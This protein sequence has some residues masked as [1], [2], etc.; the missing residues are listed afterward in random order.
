MKTFLLWSI[1]IASVI[2]AG[3]VYLLF[4]TTPEKEAVTEI[5]EQLE[6][7]AEE[8]EVSFPTSGKGSFEALMARGENLECTIS[9]AASTADQTTTEGTYFTAAGKM[10]GDFLVTS[11]GVQTVSSVIMKENTLYS[12][13]EIEGEAYGMKI[14]M[15]ELEASKNTEGTPAA[16]EVVPLDAEVDYSCKAWVAVDNSI[17]EP[18]SDVLFRDFGD[19]VNMGMEF[20]N[21]FEGGEGMGDQC[22]ACDSLTGSDKS[23]C[24]AMMSCE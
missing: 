13:T 4:S 3:A 19:I 16:Q 21:M 14:A 17:F 15:S 7:E 23:Q 24:R 18:P 22:A 20:G 2:G 12:W 5:Q 1:G 10:R 11:S 8:N 6:I 9:Y